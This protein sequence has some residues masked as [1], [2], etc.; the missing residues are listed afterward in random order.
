MKDGSDQRKCK[1]KNTIQKSQMD[2]GAFF[3]QQC[4]PLDLSLYINMSTIDKTQNIILWRRGER[5]VLCPNSD[6]VLAKTSPKRSFSITENESFGLFSRKLV[7]QFGHWKSATK[8]SSESKFLDARFFGLLSLT[9]IF[10][11]SDE[12][13]KS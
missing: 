2:S 10:S 7:Y 4:A 9:V 5:G 11:Y 6:P 13:V 3:P 1:I 8:I 12:R